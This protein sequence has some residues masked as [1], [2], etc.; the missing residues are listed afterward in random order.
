MRN[1]ETR[2]VSTLAINLYVLGRLRSRPEGQTGAQALYL[3]LLQQM[4]WDLIAAFGSTSKLRL[5]ASFAVL[6]SRDTT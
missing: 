2:C 5:V 6:A 1:E 4:P 3:C